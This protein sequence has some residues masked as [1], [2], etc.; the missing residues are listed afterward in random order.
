MIR[1]ILG[2]G[3]LLTVALAPALAAAAD[4]PATAA[5]PSGAAQAP[6]LQL[7]YVYTKWKQFT[8]A[9]GLP[10]TTSS[11]SGRRQQSLGRHGRRPG[12]DR[13]S[14]GQ[15]RQGL[16]REGRPAV[17]GHHR[18]DV[19]TKT[20]DVWLGLFGGGL[21]RLSGRPLR[22]LAPAQQRAR[23]RRRLWRRHAGRQRLVRHDAGASRFT[24]AT[25][26]WE[27]FTEKNAPWRRSELRRLLQPADKKVYLA[28][29]GSGVLEY[30]L[31]K[32]AAARYR[33]RSTSIP[34]AR[35]RSTSTATT[36]ST[37]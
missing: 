23:Q 35:W 22:P 12:A 32:A 31:G 21:A 8:A 11:R 1:R 16:E 2:T 14:A 33:G 29:W 4:A 15:G 19:D 13:Q 10:P 27:I 34:T 24:P 36:A 18:I 25:G 30:D 28:V 3:M 9:D 6:P 5:A 7:P 37:T 26:E 20:G 17:A